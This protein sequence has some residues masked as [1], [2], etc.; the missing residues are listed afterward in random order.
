MTMAMAMAMPPL[1]D[2]LG[3]RLATLT[4]VRVGVEGSF[5]T[6]GAPRLAAGMPAHLANG[7]VSRAR[8]G[9]AASGGV[10]GG[11][12]VRVRLGF[13]V[14]LVIYSRI[15]GSKC[16]RAS[17]GDLSS[18]WLGARKYNKKSLEQ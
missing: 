5:G 15:L 7:Q 9:L 18:D 2:T 14:G 11:V 6:S 17:R 3:Y 8:A 10:R 4:R 1:H 12:R 16:S 13:E